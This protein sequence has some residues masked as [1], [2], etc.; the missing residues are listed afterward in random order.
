MRRNAPNGEE[1]L[2]RGGCRGGADGCSPRA[3]RRDGG[4]WGVW[5]LAGWLIGTWWGVAPH[6]RF[7][8]R[9]VGRSL[10]SMAVEGLHLRVCTLSSL[11]SVLWGANGTHAQR[12]DSGEILNAM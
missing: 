11:F 10:F 8:H 6:P 4:G 7:I 1:P 12:R 3:S 2:V 5:A 9:P